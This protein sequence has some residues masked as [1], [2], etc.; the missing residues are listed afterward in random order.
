M[1]YNLF[2]S[3]FLYILRAIIFQLASIKIEKVFFLNPK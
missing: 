3:I 1:I 2:D